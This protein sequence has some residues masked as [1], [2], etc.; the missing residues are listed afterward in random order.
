M[1]PKASKRTGLFSLALR[2]SS[3]NGHCISAIRRLLVVTGMQSRLAAGGNLSSLDLSDACFRPRERE[4]LAEV[5]QRCGASGV[6][7]TISKGVGMGPQARLSASGE[8][9]GKRKLFF[10]WFSLLVGEYVL[11]PTLG[12]LVCS[13]TL[14]AVLLGLGEHSGLPLNINWILG[15]QVLF[16]S[17][18]SSDSSA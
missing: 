5:V 4:Y 9:S 17:S 8:K 12:W 13:L 18:S 2:G 14:G 11:A 16:F 3:I 15:A 7:V 6:D 10:E 1:C